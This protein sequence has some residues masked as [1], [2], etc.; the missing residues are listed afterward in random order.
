MLTVE[1][2]KIPQVLEVLRTDEGVWCTT[3]HGLI[4]VEFVTDAIARVRYTLRDGFSNKESLG[5]VAEGESCEV[6]VI[7]T[8]EEIKVETTRLQ[9]KINKQ[10]G[11]LSYYDGSGTLLTKE[12]ANGGK[13]L[14]PFESYRTLIDEDSVIE[15]IKTPDGIKTVVKDA[16]KVLDRELYH[17]RVLFDWEKDEA[18]YGLG[19]QEEGTLNLRGTRQYIHQ[20]NMKIAMPLIVSTRCYGVLFETYS[21]LIFNDNAY[22]SYIYSEAVDE[23]DFY[24]ISSES[25]DGVISGYRYLTGTAVMMPKWVFGFM[26]SQERFESQEE[27]IDVVKKY[28]EEEIPLD[29]MVLDWMSWE[30]G[31]W[32]QKSFDKS[33]FP[34]VRKMTD[35]LHEQ[36]VHF[37]LSIW[38]NMNSI[39]ANYEE[40][41]AA[42]TLFQQSEIYDAFSSKARELYWKQTDEGLFSKGVDAW[43]CDSCEP[44]TPEWNLPVKPEPDQNCIAFHTTAKM[45][46]DEANTNAFPLVHAKTMYEGQRSVTDQKRVV[47]LTRSAFTGQQRYGTI[48]WSGDIAAKWTTLKH[49]IPAGLNLCAS[50]LP[51]WTLDIGAFFVKQ[52]HMWFWDGDYEAGNEDLGYLELYTRWFQYGAFLP[53]FRAHG[54]DVRRELWHAKKEELPFYDVLK[55]YI[56]MRYSLLPYIY[57]LAGQV[58]FEHASMMRPLAFDFGDDVQVHSITDQYMFGKEL[59]ICPVTEPMYYGVNSIRLENIKKSRTVYLPSKTL[60]YDFWTGDCI[61]GGKT[62]DAEAPLSIMPIYVKAGSILITTEPTLSSSFSSDSELL[63]KVYPGADGSFVLYQDEKDNYHYENGAYAKIEIRWEDATSELT[64][65]K[66]EGSFSGMPET[67]KF[68]VQIQGYI[69]CDLSYNGEVTQVR[70]EKSL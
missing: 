43:W 62:I 7:E 16:K 40:M 30:D 8:N 14:T 29:C 37:M 20:A 32:G 33:R 47:N 41:K 34:D 10:N 4:A 35:W 46:M 61:E 23:S 51:Y 22:G 25:M 11:A 1:K 49:Q 24:F 31:H 13:E 55:D 21:P 39:T 57:S 5:I 3:T 15:H 54:T 64:L 68:T 45:Y 2:R 60:W 70:M 53:V 59:M 18:L 65:S 48:L 66:R 42:G 69:P 28:R 36:G 27:I 9:I 6:K 26:Q 56:K 67:I 19:Q 17:A 58:T 52:G 63:I 50:G 38:P 44:V 12:P